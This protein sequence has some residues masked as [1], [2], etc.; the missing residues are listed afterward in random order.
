LRDR[1][2]QLAR[3]EVRISTCGDVFPGGAGVWTLFSQTYVTQTGIGTCFR[4][5]VCKFTPGAGTS[6]SVTVLGPNQVRFILDL[7]TVIP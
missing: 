1:R 7:N 2:E 6:G 4:D 5:S 3:A